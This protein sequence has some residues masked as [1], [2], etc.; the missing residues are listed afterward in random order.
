MIWQ[1]G[2]RCIDF[3][4]RVH[5]MGIL[6]VTPDSFYDGG[7]FMQLQG[8]VEHALKLEEEG[9]DIIDIGG[10]STRPPLYGDSQPVNSKEE[11]A[12]V[13]P[14][15]ENIRRHSAVAISIDT[16][17]AEVARRALQAGANII[18]DISALR[19]DALMAEVAVE[20]EVPVILMHMRGTPTTMQRY[21]RYKDI[22]GEVKGFLEKRWCWAIKAGIRAD[23]IALDPGL[24]FAK[25]VEG[26]YTL[27]RSLAELGKLKA[28]LVLGASR[29]SF[30]WKPFGLS[31]AGALGGSLAIALEG[32]RQG[33]DIL[34]VHDVAATK[35]ALEVVQSIHS[36]ETAMLC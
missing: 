31:P 6:N 8:A 33:C 19:A 15:I 21:T 13:V 18:N 12:R 32:V 36:T 10:E 24:G 28:P 27:V 1:W 23:R 17:K 26:N 9:A 22:V 25:S 16:S 34:R 4:K 29:K 3:S 30:L 2:D 7:H 14:V 20:Q 35:N 5:I 11:C